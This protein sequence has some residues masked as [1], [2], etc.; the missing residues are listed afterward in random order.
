MFLGYDSGLR[1]NS[2]HAIKMFYTKCKTVI[3]CNGS[4]FKFPTQFPRRNSRDN[5][6]SL[7]LNYLHQLVLCC[8]I[9]EYNIIGKRA[10]IYLEITK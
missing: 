9:S 5:Y 2:L 1:N 7:D 6:L 8:A 4:A 3:L 10:S